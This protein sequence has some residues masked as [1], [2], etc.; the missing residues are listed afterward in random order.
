MAVYLAVV[1]QDIAPACRCHRLVTLR[2][3]IDDGQPPLTQPDAGPVIAPQALVVRSAVDQRRGHA[4]DLACQRG[5]IAPSGDACDAAHGYLAPDRID[6]AVQTEGT[7]EREPNFWS[8]QTEEMNARFTTMNPLAI[9][10]R[11]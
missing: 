2:R 1:G 9:E 8:S 7:G 4:R 10:K 5:F 3:Q 11:K 6:T